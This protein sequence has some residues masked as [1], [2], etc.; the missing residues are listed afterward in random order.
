MDKSWVPDP[1]YDKRSL[2]PGIPEYFLRLLPVQQDKS[3]TPLY[4][5]IDSKTGT[6]IMGAQHASIYE[7]IIEK[8]RALSFRTYELAN[9][10]MRH[11]TFAE[12]VAAHGM[13]FAGEA[14]IRLRGRGFACGR[15]V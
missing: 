6:V 12:P 15:G 8:T 10:M 5:K 3:C 14:E 13:G 7:S 2:A 9:V 1:A 11:S 4:A